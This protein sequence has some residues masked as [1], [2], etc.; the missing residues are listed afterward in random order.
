M[1]SK[2]LLCYSVLSS[3]SPL[4]CSCPSNRYLYVHLFEIP[5]TV[6]ILEENSR[7]LEED[8]IRMDTGYNRILEEWKRDEK[9][10]LDVRKNN[11]KKDP[12][13]LKKNL[14]TT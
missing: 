2:H 11:L 3:W 5:G 8:S 9:K 10:L 12:E 13:S 14:K 6:K 7:K 1:S 4:R